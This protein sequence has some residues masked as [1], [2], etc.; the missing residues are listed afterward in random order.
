M[1][2]P[3]RSFLHRYVSTQFHDPVGLFIRLLRTGHPAAYFAMATAGL[4]I[5]LTPLDI[6]LQIFEKRLYENA[7]PPRLP[8]IFV[9][10]APRTGSTFFTQVLINNLPVNFLNNLTSIFPLSPLTANRLFGRFLMPGILTYAS[11]YGKSVNFS[12]PNDALYIWD[13][14]FGEDRAVIPTGLSPADRENMIRFF[15]AWEQFFQKP[16]INKNN[17]LNTYANLVAEVFENAC[18]ICMTRDPLYLAQSL[19]N[20]RMDIHGNIHTPY[21]IDSP[22]HAHPD[23]YIESVCEQVLFYEQVTKEQQAIIGEDRFWIVQYEEFC[24][25]PEDIIKRVSEEILGLQISIEDLK[26]K[27]KPFVISN[28][29]KMDL[30]TFEALKQTLEHMRNHNHPHITSGETL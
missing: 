9:C 29:I 25:H 4:G 17:S 11:Y 26:A 12:G 19:L 22:H 28:A 27:L 20:A 24:R 23:N 3:L 8:L 30:A 14:W 6:L 2:K 21:G 1:F 15:G 16:L 5:I 10:G 13:R 7:S 18:F